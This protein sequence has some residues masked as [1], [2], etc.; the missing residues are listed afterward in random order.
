MGRHW[1]SLVAAR[2]QHYRGPERVQRAQM[3]VPIV[4]C[5]IEYGPDQ[6]IKTR[7]SIEAGN[8]GGNRRFGDL[9]KAF[10]V[11]NMEIR[12]GAGKRQSAA[13]LQLSGRPD[14]GPT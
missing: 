11:L 8:Q 9:G 1:I 13:A 10:H 6:R 2:G 7:L 5:V 3:R 14:I 4:D 12:S